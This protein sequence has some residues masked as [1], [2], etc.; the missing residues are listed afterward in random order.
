[1]V[2]VLD[3]NVKLKT[4]VWK[5]NKIWWPLCWCTQMPLTDPITGFATHVHI[6][7]VFILV[8][9]HEKHSWPVKI[10]NDKVRKRAF[11]DIET[12]IRIPISRRKQYL[13]INMLSRIKIK[14]LITQKWYRSSR[15]FFFIENAP[16]THMLK[17][18][19]ALK[20]CLSALKSFFFP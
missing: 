9:G 10:I 4:G 1:M 6:V 14:I 20:N 2:L 15:S 12:R 11:I 19:C 16:I 13:D 7:F 8:P 3:D 18:R 17:F 5:K